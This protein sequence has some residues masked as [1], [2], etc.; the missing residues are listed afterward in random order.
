MKAKL[1]P[2]LLLLISLFGCNEED[3]SPEAKIQGT[4]ERLLLVNDP[5]GEKKFDFY[6]TYELRSDGTFYREDVTRNVGSD[7]VLGFRTFANGTYTLSDGVVTFH[8]EDFSSMQIE[9]IPYLPKEQLTFSDLRDF[10]DQYKIL[11]NYM[12]LEYIC[13]SNAMCSSFIPAYTKIN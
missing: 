7:E 10:S 12:Q 13:P 3:L 2:A 8:Y 5:S 11:N 1:F 4:Y 9:D 6:D